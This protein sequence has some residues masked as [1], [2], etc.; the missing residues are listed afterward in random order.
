MLLKASYFK[1]G[2]I[3]LAGQVSLAEQVSLIKQISLAFL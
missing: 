1:A 2:L 3:S